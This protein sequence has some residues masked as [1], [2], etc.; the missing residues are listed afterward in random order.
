[1]KIQSVVEII[2]RFLVLQLYREKNME[3]L[4]AN[5]RLCNY[6]SDQRLMLNVFEQQAAYAEKIENYLDLK[7]KSPKFLENS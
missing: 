6:Q 3:N 1:M 5:C 4:I 7:V 2:L